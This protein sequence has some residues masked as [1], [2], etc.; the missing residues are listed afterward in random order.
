MELLRLI[1]REY[2]WPFIGVIAASLASA[3]L[4]I[5]V[6][7]FINQRLITLD[8][9]ALTVLPGFFGLILLLLAISLIAQLG[10]TTLGHY[11]VFDLRTRLVK[12]ILDTDIERLETIG[13]G[14][15]LASLSADVRYVT[16]AFV[17][18]PELVQ[19]TIL[20][21]GSVFYLG[22]LSLPILAV[23]S[24]WIAVT[25]GVGSWLVRRV[26][27][28]LNEIREAE[29]D[30]YRDYNTVIAGRKELALNR[31][32]ARRLFEDVYRQDALRYRRHIIRA[33]TY[34]MGANN[35]ANIM[36][37]AAIGLVFFLANGLGWA[38]TTVAATYALTLLFLRAPMIQAVG[39][40]PTLL[41]AQVAFNKLAGLT[42]AAHH[43]GFETPCPIGRD[44]Q[45]LQLEAVHFRYDSTDGRGFDT[46]FGIGPIDL[47]VR[48]GE[49]IFIIGG[50]GSGKTTLA[51]VLTGLY[52][53]TSGRIAVD[54]RTIDNSQRPALRGLFASVFT[55]FHLFDRL[56]GP[57]GEPADEQLVR[58]WLARL[59]MADKIRVEDSRIL[60]MQLSQG[61]RKRMGLL[62]ALAEERDILLLDEWAAD[63]DPIFRRVFYRTL[64]PALTE[65][66][67]TVI[68]ISHD[69]HYFEHADRL[70][71]M[72]N[73]RL[74]EL[75]GAE[76]AAASRDA[77]ARIS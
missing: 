15:L 39:A 68:A 61:Q 21:L 57:D 13:G 45:T 30:L 28:H 59:G 1:L 65:R 20:T 52:Q 3:A 60:D 72:R 46:G 50:N 47:T 37:L 17:R 64:L 75:T 24:V 70:L 67:Y 58:D 5:G 69:D 22:W 27:A 7:A 71:E 43:L 66:G 11:F 44:W 51:R 54:G 25:V 16:V 38:N 42:L 26:Y 34:H 48:R 2:R 6:I 63:Q 41:N 36:M 55:D 56:L 31:H 49:L 76:R 18:L 73:G 10:L 32:R 23:T 9:G 12:Q 8:G 53:A 74:T 33:D 77:V 29:D 4:G 62:I 40:L 19:G 14:A 35:W